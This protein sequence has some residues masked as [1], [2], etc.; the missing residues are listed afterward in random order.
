MVTPKRESVAPRI[1]IVTVSYGSAEVL[2]PFLESVKVATAA[3]PA[4]VVADNQ[5]D[6]AVE[7]IAR[8]HG[9]T[10]LPMESNGGYGAGMNAGVAALPKSVEW[11]LVSNPD[12]LLSAGAIDAL[13]RTGDEDP[14]IATVGPAILNADGTIYPSARAVPSLRTGVGHALFTNFWPGNPWTTAYRN[15]T[16]ADPTRRDTGWLSGACVLVRRSAFEQLGGFDPG[17]FMYFEDVDLGYRLGKAGLRNVY[18]PAAVITHSGAH[19]TTSESALMVRVHHDSARRF[20]GKKYS[21]SILWPVR[22]SLNLGLRLR[23]AIVRR[24]LQG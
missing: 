10:Y 2:E 13:V 1:G 3:P 23:S 22:V 17:Y 24:R 11:L 5:P 15:D 6:A 21:R 9:A 20:L 18:E 12:V 4:I 16:E 8:R 7:G 14:S 19:S